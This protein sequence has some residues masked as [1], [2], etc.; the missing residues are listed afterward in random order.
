MFEFIVKPVPTMFVVLGG[1]KV[2]AES[3]FSVLENF[4]GD[5]Y[6]HNCDLDTYIADI[7][8]KEGVLG[9]HIGSRMA[10]LYKKLINLRISTINTKG[11]YLKK[12]KKDCNIKSA[13]IKT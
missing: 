9:K 1:V 5:D 4:E 3:V 6:V 7:L 8:V 13:F 11:S 12:S 10:T 2:E